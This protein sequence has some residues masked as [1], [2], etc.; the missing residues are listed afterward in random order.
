M[1]KALEAKMEKAT[2]VTKT[3][4]AEVEKTTETE[5][6]RRV[7]VVVDL[8]NNFYFVRFQSRYDYLRALTDGPWIV[9]GHY[10]TVEPWKPQFN[11]ITHK[12]TSIVGWV[13][14]PNLS[15]EYYDRRLLQTVCNGI[16]CLVRL[17]HNTEEALRGRYARVA[18]EIDLSK[19]LQSQ[20]LVDD[21]WYH[22]AYVN[23]PDIC[24]ECGL[25][26]LVM[27]ECPQRVQPHTNQEVLQ[28]DGRRIV[29]HLTGDQASQQ[30]PLAGSKQPRGEWMI[31]G[32]KR[33]PQRAGNGQQNKETSS[34][35][36]TSN[37]INSGS[38]FDIFCR[39]I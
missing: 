28:P 24:F 22:I 9:L 30:P 16:G 19:P 32:R 36:E 2:Q 4:E 6:G 1:T 13:Q 35:K 26:G 11:P 5:V 31:A 20:V 33:R 34:H 29:N 27:S 18:V 38:R 10:L 12:V 25:V 17:D 37:N 7:S 23:I 39:I 3:T 8:E 15:S 21:T 14:I